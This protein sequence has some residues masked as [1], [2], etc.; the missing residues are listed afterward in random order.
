MSL[1]SEDRAKTGGVCGPVLTAY[2]EKEVCGY[3]H[4]NVSPGLRDCRYSH[5]TAVS[6]ASDAS[7]I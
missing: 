7:S 2:T 5:M 3:A 1:C 6:A 4:A